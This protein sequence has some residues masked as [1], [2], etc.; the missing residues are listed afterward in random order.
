MKTKWSIRSKFLIPTLGLIV[1]GMGLT[2][3]ISYYKAGDAL[4]TALVRELEQMAG[5]IELVMESWL[6][7]RKLDISNWSRQQVYNAA[8]KDSYM[9]RMARKSANQIMAGL[10]EDYGCYQNI[11]LA[12]PSGNVV[13]AAVADDSFVGD[14]AYFKAAMEGKLTISQVVKSEKTG[15]PVFIIAAPVKENG[16]PAG[17]FFGVLDMS[18]FNAKFI[19]PV[20]VGQNGYAYL[21]NHDGYM[22]AHPDKKNILKLNV[23]DFSFGKEMMKGDGLMTYPWQGDKKTVAMKTIDELECIIGVSAVNSEIMKPVSTFGR[24]NLMVSVIVAM[25]AGLAVFLTANAVVRSV[26][27]VVE[28]LNQS[29]DKVASASAMVSSAS[30]TLAEEA[31]EQAASIEETSS[32]LEKVSSMTRQNASNA[33][34]ADKLA[35]EA[36]EVVGN[37]SGS[38]RLM[39]GSMVEISESAEETSKIIKTIDEIAFQTNLLA[40]NAAI[41]AARAGEAGAGFA[42][43]ADEVRNLALRAA[44]AAGSTGD[45]IESTVKKVREGSELMTFTAT[46]FTGISEIVGKMASLADEIA[47][48][49]DEQAHGI[50]Q[51]NIAIAEIDSVVH[52]NAANA[53]ESAGASEDMRAQA[54]QLKGFVDELAVLVGWKHGLSKGF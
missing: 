46:E 32:S 4:R 39:T 25:F 1:I 27:N 38:M 33:S 42:V 40:L 18:V 14:Q 48:R 5:N 11:C 19:D 31:S 30:H 16:N 13:A 15:M 41:E 23:N 9:G 7:D 24:I 8:I 26:N 10:K 50:E 54:G 52:R 49:S 51:M 12:D 53:E 28:G 34:E 29:A 17:V 2:S 22:L 3:G 6:T 36:R 45:L 20:K 37:A 35:R 47:V 21:I 43:V 44:H